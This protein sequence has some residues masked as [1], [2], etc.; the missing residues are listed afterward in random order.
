MRQNSK[1]QNAN[2]TKQ[3]NTNYEYDKIQQRLNTNVKKVKMTKYKCDIALEDK[4]T[5]M[6]N[7]NQV[8]L[9]HKT[10]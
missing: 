1:G 6:T 9:R 5:N 10:K 8:L 7:Y 3:K 2:L 4:K